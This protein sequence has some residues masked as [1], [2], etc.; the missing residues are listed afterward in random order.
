MVHRGV[1]VAVFEP[2]SHF[3]GS[4]STGPVPPERVPGRHLGR[5][6]DRP[7]DAI[8]DRLRSAETSHRSPRV[9]AGWL[10]RPR[11]AMPG[12]TVRRARAATPLGI[13]GERIGVQLLDV[14]P[15]AAE[16][17]RTSSRK[18]LVTF[19]MENRADPSDDQSLVRVA[20]EQIPLLHLDRVG[21]GAIR[22]GV[23]RRPRTDVD[24][25]EAPVGELTSAIGPAAP[26]AISGTIDAAWP[27]TRV[28]TSAVAGSAA[29]SIG[30]A[31]ARRAA[32]A[33][34]PARP[35]RPDRPWHVVV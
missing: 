6:V 29:T 26:L 1:M 8:V 32:G 19:R 34:R 18:P 4:P 2:G 3:K 35:G 30:R 12:L 5:P 20:P 28:A 25:V 31:T 7:A 33:R 13:R 16:P 22:V 27:L 14:G 15:S 23:E 10:L 24:E 11:P 17:S 9:R 21:R